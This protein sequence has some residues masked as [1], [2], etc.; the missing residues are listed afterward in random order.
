MYDNYISTERDEYDIASGLEWVNL[1]YTCTRYCLHCLL[2]SAEQ[3]HLYS[4]TSS[5]DIG[6]QPNP[7][8]LPQIMDTTKSIY[9]NIITVLLNDTICFG[10]TPLLACFVLGQL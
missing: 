10:K 1:S 7:A 6:K 5:I 2:C 4:F 8:I 9:L 3:I